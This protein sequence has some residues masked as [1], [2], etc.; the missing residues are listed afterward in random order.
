MNQNEYILQIKDLNKSFGSTHANKNINFSLKRGEIR[1]LAGENGSGKS[2]LLSQIAGI[3]SRDSGL[4]HV[5]GETYNPQNPLD[6]NIKKIAI[7]VQELGLVSTLP[8]GVNVF[9]GRTKQFS[10]F[11]VISLKK[12][13]QA[14]NEQLKKWNLPELPFHKLAGEMNVETRKMIELA[15]ALSIDPDILILDEVTQALSHDNRLKLYELIKKFKELGKAVILITH[16]LDEMVSITD[17]ISILRDGELVETVNKGEINSDILKT[18]MVGRNLEGEYY[19]EDKEE[20]FEDEVVLEVRNVTIKDEIEDVS[21]DV[22]KGEILGFCGLSDSGIHTIG[23]IVYG[24]SKLN[25]G[26]VY[27]KSK[28]IYIKNQTKALDNGMAYVPKDRDGEALMIAASIRDNFIMPSIE[29]VKGSLGYL[30]NSKLNQMAENAKNNFN[31]KCTGINQPMNGL[32]GGNKQKVNLGR[33]LIKDLNVLV[34][35]CPT[36]GVDIGVKAYLYQCLKEAKEKGIAII[37]ITDELTEAI[38]MS[39]TIIVMKN[40]K[41]QKTLKRSSQFSEESII[42]VMI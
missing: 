2:T 36:R 31:V 39:D 11:G 17:S 30:S 13:Y 23:K 4:M 32:S 18:K 24:L 40:G 20:S 16:D 37:L 42:E 3:Y 1:G 7:V 10:K 27:L 38:G 33:W 25:S 12:V 29:N 9:L 22:H 35:D 34:I 8:G 14:A 21:F 19:R 15:R 6:A 41:I 28:D 26:T 5:N